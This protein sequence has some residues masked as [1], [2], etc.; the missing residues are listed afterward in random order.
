M[1]RALAALGDK[2]HTAVEWAR[3]EFCKVGGL[4]VTLDRREHQF[5][6]PLGRHAF[7]FQ[8]IRQTEAAYDQVGLNCAASINLIFNVLAFGDLNTCRHHRHL[9]GKVLLV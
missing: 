6:C 7:G 2:P 1:S 4:V 8:W 5:D 9:F 3:E